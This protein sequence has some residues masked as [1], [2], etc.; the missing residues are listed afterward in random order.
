MGGGQVFSVKLKDSDDILKGKY[1]IPVF[2][3]RHN[4]IVKMRNGLYSTKKTIEVKV[5]ADEYNIAP[6]TATM[7]VTIFSL[8]LMDKDEGI[9]KNGT[10]PTFVW[11]KR[12]EAWDYDEMPEN[13][14]TM[15]IASDKEIR[16]NA[17]QDVIYRKTSAW[18]KELYEINPS[19]FFNLFYNDYFAYGWMQATIGND[20]PDVNYKVVLLSDGTASF[21]FF[22]NHFDNENHDDE[23]AK[24]LRRY[25][26]LKKQ[27]ARE[28]TYEELNNSFVVPA[29][30]SNEYAFLMVKEEKNVEWW[31]TRI[32]G[33]LAPN[34]PSQY[35]EISELAEEGKIKVKDLKGLLMALNDEEKADLKKLYNFSDTMFEKASE[36]NK[37]VMII[38]GTW[39]DD[40]VDFD[41]YVKAV[42]S[43]YGENYVYYYKGHPRNPTNSV[44]GK[45]E[46][47]NSL[48]LVD[49]DSTIPAELIF[50]FNPDACGVGY[51][52]STFVSLTD[53]QSGGVFAV[54]KDDFNKSLGYYDKLEFFITR[55]DK[56]DETFGSLAE[57]GT[58]FL[59]EFTKSENYDI[60]VFNVK[61]LSL[62]FYKARRNG[63]VVEYEEVV[64]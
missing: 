63:D 38:L 21:E 45:L 48:G 37:K 22:N 52:S 51:Q 25:T 40:E 60:A 29:V 16:S 12:S 20:I 56:S 5:F 26:L 42:Q 7:P 47:L 15:P 43:Y 33:T 57:D 34:T 4:V 24:M 11:F 8:S 1:T 50:F 35:S 36:E 53:E 18:I 58:S 10:I 59:F 3:G 31:L 23:Y 64:L 61:S 44:Q 55:I 54:R 62:R 13:V 9:T 41:G 28:G 19:S 49:V 2:Y 14:F 30:N 32:D 27:V 46:H 17:G 6:I 39:T